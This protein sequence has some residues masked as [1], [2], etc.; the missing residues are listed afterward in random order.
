MLKKTQT[1]KISLFLTLCILQGLATSAI[2][3]D[4]MGT[5]NTNEMEICCPN[6]ICLT[7]NHKIR[8]HLKY[9]EVFVLSISPRSAFP[10]MYTYKIG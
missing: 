4:S 2:S 8:M 10:T 7:S 1:L 5:Q 9:N 3:D 6:H